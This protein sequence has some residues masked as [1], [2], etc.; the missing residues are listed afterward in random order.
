MVLFF[1]CF[2]GFGEVGVFFFGVMSLVNVF[3]GFDEVDD[4][5]LLCFDEF[6]LVGWL[7]MLL[8]FF[9]CL[10]IVKEMYLICS[11]EVL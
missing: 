7:M 9:V 3:F 2:L 5:L 4:G 10:V 1:G 11:F 8:I 6:V